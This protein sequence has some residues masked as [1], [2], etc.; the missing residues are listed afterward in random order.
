MKKCNHPFLWSFLW[1]ALLVLLNA[2]PFSAQ[3]QTSD[4]QLQV[5]IEGFPTII[6]F[7]GE[8]QLFREGGAAKGIITITKAIDQHSPRLY[9]MQPRGARLRQITILWSRRASNG[10]REVFLRVHLEDTTLSAVHIQLPNQQ[11]APGLRLYEELSFSPAEVEWTYYLPGGGTVT[12][13][14]DYR[15]QR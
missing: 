4:V 5:D 6:A 10:G 15:M 11:Q 14:F 2:S 8:Q 9:E 3:A 7:G 13:R 12:G 1:T